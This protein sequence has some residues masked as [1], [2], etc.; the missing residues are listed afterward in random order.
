MGN[1]T[2]RS[3]EDSIASLPATME[4]VPAAE[5]ED[6]IASH[7]A[8]PAVGVSLPYEGV[9]LQGLPVTLSPTAEEVSAARTG[10]TPASLAI[11]DYGSVV[12]GDRNDGA[13]PVSLFVNEHVAVVRASDVVESMSDA[14]DKLG[15]GVR[16]GLQ[17][18]VIATGPSA[19]AD[20]GELVH[21]V[22]GPESVHVIL[23]SDR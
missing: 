15:D 8:E 13:E 5:F 18:A 4:Q 11:G 10:I 16:D 2:I 22:H 21:G 20:M 1:T 19:T 9:S 7:L 14:V 17:S 12:V 6:A 23:L 3:F